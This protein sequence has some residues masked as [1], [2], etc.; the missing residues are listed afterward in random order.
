MFFSRVLQ[1]SGRHGTGCS[2]IFFIFHIALTIIFAM[3][4]T[5]VMS[6]LIGI[7]LVALLI[8]LWQAGVCTAS[9]SKSTDCCDNNIL[10]NTTEICQ[11]VVDKNTLTLESANDEARKLFQRQQR[12]GDVVL[13]EESQNADYGGDQPNSMLDDDELARQIVDK[14]F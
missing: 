13:E 5:M 10:S 9:Q 7:D 6:V 1:Q 14:V 3:D 4:D 11:L 12:R 2:L 8:F